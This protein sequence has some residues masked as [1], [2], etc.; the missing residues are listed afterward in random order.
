MR[1]RRTALLDNGKNASRESFCSIWK[2]KQFYLVL[3]EQSNIAVAAS[4]QDEETCRNGAIDPESSKDHRSAWIQMHGKQ[5]PSSP[6][7]REEDDFPQLASIK[8]KRTTETERRFKANCCL[9]HP[10][11][12][13]CFWRAKKI[14]G[15]FSSLGTN[16]EDPVWWTNVGFSLVGTYMEVW[17]VAKRRRCLRE[18]LSLHAE[19]LVS[20][21]RYQ[22]GSLVVVW[23]LF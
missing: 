14:V 10:L 7:P 23:L 4:V 20:P 17:G 11:A 3:G 9:K 21:K 6:K 12:E 8:A 2:T 18:I 15:S 5:K 16:I 13:S 19:M 22:R 1:C